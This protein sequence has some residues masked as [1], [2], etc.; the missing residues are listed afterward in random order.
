[1]TVGGAGGNSYSRAE[2]SLAVPPRPPPTVLKTCRPGRYVSAWGGEENLYL[3]MGLPAFCNRFL[4]PPPRRIT[5]RT[6]TAGIEQGG[7]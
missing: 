5:C 3:S 4:S 7:G 6:G 1:M 2:L